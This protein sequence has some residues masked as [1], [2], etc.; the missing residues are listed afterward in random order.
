MP[1]KVATPQSRELRSGSSSSTAITLTDIKLLIENL[2]TEVINTLKDEVN[3]LRDTIGSLQLQVKDLQGTNQ[4]LQRRCE[5]VEAELHELKEGP[6]EIIDSITAEIED[7]ARRKGNVI[8]HGLPECS[9]DDPEESDLTKCADIMKAVSCETDGIVSINR[10]GKPVGSRPRLLKVQCKDPEFRNRLLRMAKE[11]RKNAKFRG[12][13]INPD[14]TPLEQKHFKAL[15]NELKQRKDC[16]EDV[17]IFRNHV[18]H[19]RDIKNF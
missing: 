18:V 19:R 16:N 10:I 9:S 11:L 7:R 1:P 6:A 4:R 15:L 14:R 13:F 2:R 5:S 12:I 17:V 8:I 3:K